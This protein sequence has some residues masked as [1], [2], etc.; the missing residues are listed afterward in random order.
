MER[1]RSLAGDPVEF[2]GYVPEDELPAL[3]ARCQALIFPGL[4]D[5]GIVPVQAQAAG[6]PVI[7]FRGGG[8][9]DTVAPAVSGEFFARASV[10]SLKRVWRNFDPD[11]YNPAEIRRAALRFDTSVFIQRITAFIEQAWQARESGC[12]FAYRDPVMAAQGSGD[13]IY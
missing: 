2:L 10:D 12:Q 9:L 3:M 11:A 6:R 5:F 7:A 4:E 1:L 8:A 13:G